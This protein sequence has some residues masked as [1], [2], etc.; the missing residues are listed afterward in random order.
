MPRARCP[1]EHEALIM[2][3]SHLCL[4]LLAI[5]IGLTAATSTWNGATSQVPQT[6]ATNQLRPAASFESI[7]DQRARS[8]ALFEEAGK[9]IQSPRCVNCHPV[10]DRPRQT[11]G[12]RLH[13]PRVE[14]GADGFGAPGMMCNTCHHANNFD[15]AGVPGVADWQLAPT[16]MTWE[17]RSLAQICEQLK[18]PARNGNR[19]IAAI[20]HHVVTDSRVIWSWSPG[21]G[22]T[23][24]PGT[25]AEFGELLRAWA[26][27]G[28]QCPTR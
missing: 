12:R 24:A 5:G 1:V 15:P 21:R 16:S 18:D 7:A 4:T 14:R 28:A 9:V 2:R 25:N 27:T 23:P 8:I 17:G 10:G 6:P 11:D 26:E 22:R 19:D 13:I 3:T 20:L